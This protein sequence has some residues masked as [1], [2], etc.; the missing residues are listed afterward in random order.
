MEKRKK[1]FLNYTWHQG[2]PRGDFMDGS[3]CK[4]GNG[5]LFFGSQNGACYFNP[6]HIIENTQIAPVKI[7]DIKS[8]NYSD[9]SSKGV[10]VPITDNKV[11]L[12]YR[13]STF[14]ISFSVMDFSQTPQ[15]EY[16]YTM[17]GLGKTGLK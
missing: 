4:D 10:I 8:Y 3:V 12:S 2:V 16:A 9:P 1:R 15:V 13:S 14:T 6:E 7:T 17:E 5:T 11:N